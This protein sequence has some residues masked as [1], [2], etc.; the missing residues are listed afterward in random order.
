[1]FDCKHYIANR[2]AVLIIHCYWDNSR[3][4]KQSDATKLEL[5]I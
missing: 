5:R 4:K 2:F 1:M 3:M